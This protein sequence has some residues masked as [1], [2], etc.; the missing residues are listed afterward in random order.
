MFPSTWTSNLYYTWSNS[1][2][3]AWSAGFQWSDQSSC[4]LVLPTEN[5]TRA[6]LFLFKGFVPR[7]KYTLTSRLFVLERVK[8]EIDRQMLVAKTS[9]KRPVSSTTIPSTP[10]DDGLEEEDPDYD[11]ELSESNLRQDL[12]NDPTSCAFPTKSDS[13][14]VTNEQTY[15]LL[16]NHSD[17]MKLPKNIEQQLKK[18]N[19]QMC[20]FID[21]ST[22]HVVTGAFGSVCSQQFVVFLSRSALRSVFRVEQSV[23]TESPDRRRSPIAL[24]EATWAERIVS[25]AIDMPSHSSTNGGLFREQAEL[26]GSSSSWHRSF[27]IAYATLPSTLWHRCHSYSWL[28]TLSGQTIGIIRIRFVLSAQFDLSCL[29]IPS[30]QNIPQ[31]QWN[32]LHSHVVH[33]TSASEKARQR[34]RQ[35]HGKFSVRSIHSTLLSES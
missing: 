26:L 10:N 4:S 2:S 32:T 1:C 7:G 29:G 27:H 21:L 28:E 31:N 19:E 15:R 8:N 24:Q 34:E 22:L 16:N 17:L 11:D 3:S 13:Q 14:C 6:R 33:E 18:P 5:D 35:A 12:T 23:V 25:T 30:R 9:G 20:T